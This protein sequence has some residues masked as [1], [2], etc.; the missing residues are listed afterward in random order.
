MKLHSPF[1]S[2]LAASLLA[3]AA[4]SASAQTLR[5]ATAGDP[6][7]TD[8]HAQNEN[9]TNNFNH[10][11]YEFLVER[12]KQLRFVP[13]LATQWTQ[14]EPLLW[15]L[16]LRPG[17]KF[18]DGRPFTADD[19]VFSVRRAQ[20]KTSQ[21]ASYATAVGEPHKVDD[22]TVEFRLQQIN[23]IFLDH[24]GSVFIM[25]RGWCEE[26]KATQPQDFSSKQELYTTF[27]AN[28]TGPYML[29]SRQPDVRTVLKRNP[30][31]WGPMEGNIQEVVYTP[32]SSDATRVAALMSGQI[33]IV[34]DPPPGDVER[35]RRAAGVRVVEGP[36]QRVIFIGLDQG[37]DELLYSSVKGKNPF[38]D[39]RV[40]RALY[41]AIDI[42][43]LRTKLMN[44]LAAPT[45]A[46]VPSPLAHHH[47]PE[48][49]K[50]L[51]YDP[52]AARRLLGEAGYAQGFEVTMDCPNNR[53]IN[54]ERICQTLASMWA[55]IGVKVRVNAM[56]KSTYFPKL[57]KLDTSLYL[58][59]WGGSITDAE[60]TFTPL[61][62]NRG[63]KGVGEYNRGNFRNDALDALAAASSREGDT[64][65]RRALVRQVFLLHNEHLH[66]LP[67]HRQI[68]PWAMARG[69]E[70][71]HRPD[72]YLEVKW[73]TKRR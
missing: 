73:V 47:D 31:Y 50:R 57:E 11:I 48:I 10:Q 68:M 30:N 61:Y 49:E 42:E 70:V 40:R 3:V 71:A 67:L 29:V 20:Q 8:P 60:T 51:P 12:D 69:V 72:N 27:H 32:I 1:W 66:Y 35:L 52:A 39:L 58:F 64:D 14:V 38:K 22:L 43:T 2:R 25:S 7:T 55:R 53:Y 65:K 19:V 6:L 9:V 44:G 36:E 37:R 33:D 15:R 62:R 16:K 23:P 34:Q 56:P 45:G 41:Q 13:G 18:H 17:V 26:H 46:V 5:W 59:G 21:I 4:C 24:L 54:D 28:G 63:E